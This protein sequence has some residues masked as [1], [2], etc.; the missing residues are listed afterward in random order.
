[1]KNIHRLSRIGSCSIEGCE[2]KILSRGYCGL[3]Y[4]RNRRLGNAEAFIPARDLPFDVYFWSRVDKSDID[5]CWLWTG[6]ANDA[7]YGQV[8]VSRKPKLAHRL[9]LELTLGR[10]ILDNQYALHGCDNPRCCRVGAGHV[11]EGTAKQNSADRDMRG[12]SNRDLMS[13]TRIERGVARGERNPRAI[14][15]QSKADDIRR[16]YH[17]DKISQEKIAAE[18][19]IRQSTVSQIIRDKIWRA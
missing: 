11:Y 8:S 5:G 18:F 17:D 1:V 16:R 12:R 19:G 7:G 9:A 14:L 15:T 3:H 2:G 4:D 10:S 13:A 6:D